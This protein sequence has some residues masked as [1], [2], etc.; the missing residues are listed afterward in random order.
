MEY[1]RK[2]LLSR[3]PSGISTTQGFPNQPIFCL[4][5]IT[6]LPVA[7]C[8][9]KMQV[10][11]VTGGIDHWKRALS[12]K[13][14]DDLIIKLQEYHNTHHLK[15]QKKKQIFA[16][17]SQEQQLN[18][19][20][21]ISSSGESVYMK[22]M[23]IQDRK[24]L[25]EMKEEKFCKDNPGNYCVQQMKKIKTDKQIHKIKFILRFQNQE[26]GMHLHSMF[27]VFL[28]QGNCGA[29]KQNPV[30]LTLKKDMSGNLFATVVLMDNKKVRQIYNPH[31][32]S[33]SLILS[34]KI[35][36]IHLLI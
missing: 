18:A 17:S 13:Q 27:S 10:L 1:H 31:I 20:L 7:S 9:T 6:R 33:F 2:L 32:F 19:C 16:T 22:E 24:R 3:Y 8:R 35:F 26:R 36:I 25:Q 12:Y 30:V 23:N 21:H 28:R 29:Y 34:C 5:K 14:Y 4:A 11:Q 15:W